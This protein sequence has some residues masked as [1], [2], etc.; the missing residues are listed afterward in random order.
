MIMLKKS[1]ILSLDYCYKYFE[2]S[3]FV[4]ISN[5]MSA[6]SILKG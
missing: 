2:Q 6:L 4:I 1:L 5:D 3:L